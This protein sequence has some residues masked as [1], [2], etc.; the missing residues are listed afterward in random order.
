MKQQR[1]WPFWTGLLLGVIA[2]SAV[3]ASVSSGAPVDCERKVGILKLGIVEAMNYSVRGLHNKAQRTAMRA[4]GVAG[5]ECS[6]Q[7]YAVSSE[8]RRARLVCAE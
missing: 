1:S 5:F 3:F 4:L 7:D 8:D 6:W 2:T